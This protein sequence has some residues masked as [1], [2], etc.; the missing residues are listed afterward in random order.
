MKKSIKAVNLLIIVMLLVNLTACTGPNQTGDGTGTT[1]S[2]ESAV[3]TG[4]GE[5][6]VLTEVEGD[7]VLQRGGSDSVAAPTVPP[8]PIDFILENVTYTSNA[9]EVNDWNWLRDE[10]KNDY[11][12]WDVAG[13]APVA[14]GEMTIEMAAFATDTFDG[15]RGFD[16]DFI[17]QFCPMTECQKSVTLPNISP[18]RDSLGYSCK[19][20]FTVPRS[21]ISSDGV[22]T[23]KIFRGKD[24]DNHISFTKQS[25]L[26]VSITP[27]EATNEDTA[28]EVTEET[29]L[30]IDQL[31]SDGDGIIDA[32]EEN[33]GLDSN[34]T[35]TDGDGVTD[36]KDLS[37]A[38]DPSEPTGWQDKQK[39]GMVRQE[40]A[41][42]AWGMDGWVETYQKRYSI[43]PPRSWLEYIDT[44]EDDGTK[45]SNMT[46]SYYKKAADLAFGDYSLTA[47]EFNDITPDDIAVADTEK[48]NDYDAEHSYTFAAGLFHPNEYR[49]YYDDITDYTMMKLKNDEEI[50]YPDEDDYFRYLLMPIKIDSGRENNFKLQFKDADL[51]SQFYYN[52][53][54][55]YQQPGF[56]YTF[57]PSND[58]NNDDM[59]PLS[60]NLAVSWLVDNGVFEVNMT[61]PQDRATTGSGY[62]KLTPVM[63]NKDG[64]ATDY[65]PVTMNW[66][67]TGLTRSFTYVNDGAG[68]VK[69]LTQ[70][71]ESLDKLNTD[72]PSESSLRSQSGGS[73]YHETSQW[74]GVINKDPEADHPY[75]GFEATRTII[76]WVNTGLSVDNTII[77]LNE[78]VELS[79]FKDIDDIG[80]LPD[81]HWARQPKYNRAVGAFALAAG[82]ASIASDS[83]DAYVAIK[84]GD[85]VDIAYYSARIT[86]TGVSTAATMIGL[87]TRTVGYTGKAT[88]F[89]KL[90]GTKAAVGLAAAAGAV[91]IIYVSYQ[92]SQADDPIESKAYK[93]KIAADVVDTGL[94][95]ASV[96]SP[97][98][99]A[100]QITWMVEVEIYGAIFGED[101]AYQVASSPGGAAMFLADYF[102][103]G[104]INSNMSTPA[105][106]DARGE[107]LENIEIH[108]A[109]VGLPYVTI[110]IDPDLE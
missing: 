33:A 9:D 65:R 20:E 34:N 2:P 45:K 62:F 13:L 44:K 108:Y 100:F 73:N 76:N 24:D 23:I 12:Q 69:I 46:E 89:A 19:G 68:N 17:V 93:E 72:W 64:N 102:F 77:S 39:I 41:M 58:F 29:E 31:D 97:H 83:M 99:L 35:D 51:Y 21:A 61:L 36:N 66:D 43:I 47:Y 67:I 49:F 96:L 50:Y 95:I 63:I 84:N 90:A 40:T 18:E 98:V 79:H 3:P 26:N 57:Y 25:I 15:G 74:Y 16:A 22:L 94:S 32:D 14:D 53:D 70:E 52:S 54:N 110:F 42:L 101:F 85:L 11:A 55:D 107:I 88:K 106:E 71:L 78:S 105:Y 5:W 82:A 48:T 4:A 38:I 59:E 7:E 104:D 37:G 109:G 60:E 30:T 28:E 8:P 56:I 91:E 103:T 86:V 10:D 81:N 80:D 27:G 87:A 6:T 1:V 75:S 92:L